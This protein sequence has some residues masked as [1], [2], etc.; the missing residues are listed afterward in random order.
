M[1]YGEIFG[2]IKD[3]CVGNGGYS[4]F[5]CVDY[6]CVELFFGRVRIYI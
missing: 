4:F 3:G 5:I 6:V 2:W 1:D